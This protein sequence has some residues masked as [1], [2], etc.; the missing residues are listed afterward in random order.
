MSGVLDSDWWAG[1]GSVAALR[2]RNAADGAT[3]RNGTGEVG[4]LY[5]LH[6]RRLERIVRVDVRA[7]EPV[8]EDACQFAWGRLLFHAHRIRRETALAW[9]TTTA[10]RHA[11]KLIGRETRELSLERVLEEE[12][13]PPD[14]LY[15]PAPDEVVEQRER[16]DALG[17]L[18]DRQQRMVWLQGLGLSY[19]EIAA[20]E[21]CTVRT[22]ERQLLRAKR[23]MLTVAPV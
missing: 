5:A 20:R 12:P 17:R 9:L 15:A 13:E 10:V 14:C 22:V 6:A 4:E 11:L 2:V 1:A 19:V 23:T 7:P 18:P 21:G 16:L 3:S 8:I